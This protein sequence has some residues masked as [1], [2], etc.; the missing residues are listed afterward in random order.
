MRVEPVE[1]HR[2]IVADGSGAEAVGPRLAHR[3]RQGV[4]V[5]LPD[6]AGR[7]RAARLDQL[8]AGGD[9]HDA[10]TRARE[11]A[12]PPHA[13]DDPQLRGPDQGARLEHDLSG[14]YVLPG[15]PDRVAHLGAAVDAYGDRAPVRP[16]DRHHGVG[17][18]RHGRAGHDAHGVAGPDGAQLDR[19][20]RH[21]VDHRQRN[22]DLRQILGPDRVPVHGRVVERRQRHRRGDVLGQRRAESLL[23]LQLQRGQ[24]T[25]SGH[26]LGQMRVN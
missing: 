14:L 12:P 21:V 23:Q 19:A 20:G 8:G 25:Y 17:P 24:R 1:Q 4:A 26:D 16:L 13:G 3:R 5:G 15:P 6:L 9:D 2:G 22:G 18:G 11:H 10:R 7:E